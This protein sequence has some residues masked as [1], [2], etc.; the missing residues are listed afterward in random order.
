MRLFLFWLKNIFTKSKQKNYI[1][2]ISKFENGKCLCVINGRVLSITSEQ[3][4]DYLNKL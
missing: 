2:L 3:Y 4:K 1:H